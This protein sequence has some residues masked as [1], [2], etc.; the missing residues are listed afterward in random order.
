MA[1]RHGGVTARYT[2]HLFCVECWTL[3]KLASQLEIENL[4]Q[5][6]GGLLD[7]YAEKKIPEQILHVLN[8]AATCPTTQRSKIDPEKIYIIRA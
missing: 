7:V 6:Y 4:N 1:N 2:V 3:H 5:K 8:Q